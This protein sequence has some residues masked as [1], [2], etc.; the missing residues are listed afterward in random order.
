MKSVNGEASGLRSGKRVERVLACND[1]YH[2]SNIIK[3]SPNNTIYYCFTRNLD[4]VRWLLITLSFFLQDQVHFA[5]AKQR[6]C[7]HDWSM[8]PITPPIIFFLHSISSDVCLE[9]L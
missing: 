4:L 7:S 8:Y 3:E 2:M 9:C 5:Q 1:T 6:V